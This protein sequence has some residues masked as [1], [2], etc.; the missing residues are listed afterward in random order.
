MKLMLNRSRITIIYKDAV[1]I[2]P[3]EPITIRKEDTNYQLTC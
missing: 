2:R 1:K 3:N